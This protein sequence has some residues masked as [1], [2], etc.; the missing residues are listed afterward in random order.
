[1][2][3]LETPG[4]ERLRRLSGDDTSVAQAHEPG[5]TSAVAP[6]HDYAGGGI[7]KRTL[8]ESWGDAVAPTVNPVVCAASMDMA[9]RHIATLTAAHASADHY[10]STE[11]AHRL[12]LVLD[13]AHGAASDDQRPTVDAL[14]A[15]A[16]PL[17]AASFTPRRDAI[18]E[19]LFG[20]GREHWDRDVA[21]WRASREQAWRAAAAPIAAQLGI[22]ATIHVDDAPVAHGARGLAKAG[23]LHLVP[24]LKPEHADA[25]HI[26]AHELVHVAQSRLPVVGPLADAEREA[27]ELA[28]GL[29]RGSLP[30]QPRIGIAASVAA[31]DTGAKTAP[32]TVAD[33]LPGGVSYVVEPGGNAARV[34]RDWLR[35]HSYANYMTL[36]FAMQLQGGMPWAT[37]K[38]IEHFAAHRDKPEITAPAVIH[39]VIDA[40]VIAE[41]GVPADHPFVARVGDRHLAVVL[42]FEIAN[43]PMPR[44]MRINI[45]DDERGHEL[46]ALYAAI[47]SFTKLKPR[48]RIDLQ[49]IATQG[50]T[51]YVSL[52][53]D[54]LWSIFG[55]QAWKH[56]LASS[57]EPAHSHAAAK[58]PPPAPQK[59]SATSSP[60]ATHAPSEL[61]SAE[62]ERIARWF[63]TA[64]LP[65]P[66]H[67]DLS[68]LAVVAQLEHDPA[69]AFEVLRLMYSAAD[70]RP[71]DSVALEA[72]IDRARIEI[73][74]KRLGLD[75]VP[76]DKRTGVDPTGAFDAPIA[77]SEKG[78]H[79]PGRT[80][81]F[82]IAFDWTGLAGASAAQQEA[83]AK[84]TWHASVEWVFERTDAP[85][86][87]EDQRIVTERRTYKTSEIGLDHVFRLDGVHRGQWTVHAF[88]HSSHFPLKHV[89]RDLEIV[90]EP[91]QMD[92]LRAEAFK[93]MA[94]EQ[95]VR[96]V[97]HFDVRA[98][99][100]ATQI[101]EDYAVSTLRFARS[102]IRRIA[103]SDDGNIDADYDGVMARGALPAGFQP[104]PDA[105]RTATRA[106]QIADTQLLVELLT[107]EQA[108]DGTR[109]YAD[110]LAAATEHLE[111]LR[112][113]DDALQADRDAKQ[114]TFELRGTYFSRQS[115]VPSGPLELYGSVVRPST[116]ADTTVTVQI[117]DLSE[118]IGAADLRF[119]ATGPTFAAALEAA[120]ID[121]C[122]AY[123]EGKI[124]ILAQEMDIE[125]RWPTHQTIGFE[126]ATTSSWTRFKSFATSDAVQYSELVLMIFAPEI[127]L[128]LMVAQDVALGADDIV[129]RV[130]SGQPVGWREVSIDAA[131]VAVDVLPFAGKAKLMGKSARLLGFTTPKLG[132]LANVAG[133][134]M[135]MGIGVHDAIQHMQEDAIPAL[136]ADYS[137]LHKAE[138]AKPEAPS[139]AKRRADILDRAANLRAQAQKMWIDASIKHVAFLVGMHKLNSK[140]EEYW[141]RPKDGGSPQRQLGPGEVHGTRAREPVPADEQVSQPKTEPTSP[142]DALHQTSTAH[143]PATRYGLGDEYDL[144]SYDVTASA[145]HGSSF[146]GQGVAAPDVD[147]VIAHAHAAFVD[148]ASARGLN[149][150]NVDA[151]RFGER[152]RANAAN[153]YLVQLADGSHISV[154]VTAGPLEGQNV[155]RTVLNPTKEG[156]SPV[157][158]DGR[159]VDQ[160]VK[161]RFVIQLSDRI[162]VDNVPR[163]LAHEMA[164]L[165]ARRELSNAGRI[166][167][168]DV[169]RAG[170]GTGELSPHDHGRIAEIEI[171]GRQVAEGGE[172]AAKAR[173]EL[174]AL[175]EDLAVRTG[176]SGAD[177]RAGRI[178]A[179]LSAEARRGFDEARTQEG[180]L[181]AASRERLA[182]QRE[183]ASADRAVQAADDA[184]REPLHEV[185]TSGL[186]H[187]ADFDEAVA[188]AKVATEERARVSKL[189]H[190]EILAQNQAGKIPVYEVQL[191]GNAALA[192]RDPSALFID[193]NQR[194]AVDRSKYLAQTADQIKD[195]RAAGL[196]NPYEFAGPND[197]VPRA[198]IVFMQDSIASQG[199][200]LDG[201][202]TIS[203]DPVTKDV[204][205]TVR[206]NDSTP[207][208]KV[209]VKGALTVASGFPK[210]ITPGADR[211]IT[212][213]Q[214][215]GKLDNALK[216]LEGPAAANLRQT[217]AQISGSNT[218]DLTAV[219]AALDAAP[220]LTALLHRTNG[221]A[222]SSLRAERAWEAMRTADLA[223]GEQH[224]F[225]GDEAN[226]MSDEKLRSIHKAVI[227]GTGGT[228]VSAAEIVLDHNSTARV[229]MVGKDAPAGLLENDQFRRVVAKYGTPELA[230]RFGIEGHG[231]GRFEFR[232]GYRLEAPER[233]GDHYVAKASVD[234]AAPAGTLPTD[235]LAPGAL[236]GDTYIS[237]L[238]RTNDVPAPVAELVLR[239]ERSGAKVT[240]TPM[241]DT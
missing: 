39:F 77:L 78:V 107:S 147:G 45:V 134:T 41:L 130:D 181:D 163:A 150:E 149:V 120:F 7:G 48:Q 238:G 74:R 204:V 21:A 172:L 177:E 64:N 31:A 179:E 225:L 84:R 140:L 145:V 97:H 136:A 62:S 25:R 174:T 131:K 106:K 164:E 191:G 201:F 34:S 110:A 114:T 175:V 116:I 3:D 183:R 223:G 17:L 232:D 57:S 108:A 38:R 124:A 214:A 231:D 121:L 71:T 89:T 182:A 129:S 127:A 122:K 42:R 67:P 215:L 203:I 70:K 94:P 194:W 43:T 9:R 158:R 195:I 83:A 133:A 166:P 170:G 187:R 144:G 51:L 189:T 68:L 18:A 229:V 162:D 240:R 13:T 233:V 4:R 168:P 143:D 132:E 190:D 24:T 220:E 101:V 73:E 118:R 100:T 241:F 103:H 135:V 54:Q 111:H 5:R 8:A 128:P 237:A 224:L 14:A 96:S 59:A 19:A 192:A 209:R 102:V 193:A 99:D 198:A 10:A 85:K 239:A 207:D 154:R 151:Q 47:E 219:N 56:W 216:A 46:T 200:V 27:D 212:P 137:E 29:V 199:P 61:T 210:E 206:M 52:N 205:I 117:R 50:D 90:D 202:G 66:A 221:A 159:T 60:A 80:M 141:N 165:L 217:L 112:A 86:L 82:D 15:E 236:D 26:L 234:G 30:H 37:G 92:E 222:I 184:S 95:A 208:V 36:L 79:V 155:A 125:G 160:A 2:G 157:V 218:D 81:H 138:I 161:G 235:Q 69:L 93:D 142:R 139:L 75:A 228:G 53:E 33:A 211:F 49:G 123:P 173:D 188:L 167:G 76:Q 196:G 65:Q 176:V 16:A 153:T 180:A 35:E 109:K 156:L 213:R 186:D 115:E 185:P 11:A 146:K 87:P 6:A 197:R 169:L 226:A 126:L 119:S 148:V 55:E 230:Q 44:G 227:G 58:T 113:T 32:A 23:V 22:E 178:S 105:D 12:R 152:D 63:A 171:V 88:V 40:L 20:Q 98:R 1:M 28:A 72:L 91:T 104:T